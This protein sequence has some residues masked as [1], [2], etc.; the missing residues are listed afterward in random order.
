MGACS[1][2]SPSSPKRASSF[3]RDWL[4][5]EMAKCNRAVASPASRA[6]NSVPGK[7]ATLVATRAI[8][9]PLRNWRS[10]AKAC[11][12]IS[13]PGS[14]IVAIGSNAPVASRP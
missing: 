8:A 1:V 12:P 4:L 14:W 11:S 3:S 6:L 7:T 2:S 13:W 10:T 9:V 5:P